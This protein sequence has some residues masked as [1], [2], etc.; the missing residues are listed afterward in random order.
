MASNS[1]TV[2]SPAS[3]KYGYEIGLSWSETSTNTTNNTSTISVTGYIYGKNISYSSSSSNTLTIYWHDNNSH[4]SDVTISTKAVA[5]TTKGTKN[6][7]SGTITV[8]H[9]SDGTLSGYAKVKFTKGASN[10]YVPPT[11]TVSTSSVNLTKIPRA[12][13][14]PVISGY[15]GSAVTINLARASSSFT[16]RIRYAFG[17]LSGTIASNVATSYNWTIPT[18]FYAQIGTTARSKT[19]TLYVDTYNGSTLVGTKSSTFTANV[20]EASAKLTVSISSVVDDDTNNTVALTGDSTILIAHASNALVSFSIASQSNSTVASITI[21]GNS[22]PVA[23]RTFS[24]PKITSQ[25]VTVSATDSR[26]YVTAATYTI[27]NEKWIA[28]VPVSIVGKVERP[29]GVSTTV[30]VTFNG[31]YWTGNFGSVSNS[32]KVQ[33]RYQ[34]EGGSWSSWLPSAGMAYT[35]S[36]TT[37]EQTSTVAVTGISTEKVYNWQLKATDAIN[38][39]GMVYDVTTSKAV[40]VFW[41]NDDSFNVTTDLY[42]KGVNITDLL[43]GLV[44]TQ[45]VNLATNLTVNANTQTPTATYT[46]SPRDGYTPIFV[47][48]NNTWGGHVTLW[49]CSLSGNTISWRIRN[50]TSSQI[51]G[52]TI[53]VRVLYIKSQ[54]FLGLV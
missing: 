7:L 36:G 13:N 41:W 20:R 43:T 25:T 34:E 11:T 10:S 26:G 1:T 33:Y 4:T 49:Y 39:D 52:F 48:L 3:S 12:T 32:L 46:L 42:N 15:V 47:A 37:Y 2:Y 24:I 50:N 9:K 6:T 53:Q 30:G 51:T 17:S 38:T 8:P 14:A 54:C 5:K 21:N 27:P 29:D 19:G 18:S 28:Y 31:N 44:Y 22:V 16:H 35:T 23:N 45:N 40:P